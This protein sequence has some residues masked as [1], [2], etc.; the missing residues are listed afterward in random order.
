[1][2]RRKHHFSR[3]CV[4]GSVSVSRIP[5]WGWLPESQQDANRFGNYPCSKTTRGWRWIM[6]DNIIMANDHNFQCGIRESPPS[7]PE[8]AFVLGSFSSHQTPELAEDCQNKVGVNF[9][10]PLRRRQAGHMVPCKLVVWCPTGTCHKP[11]RGPV[12]DPHIYTAGFFPW[13]FSHVGACRASMGPKAE[14]TSI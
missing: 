13:R 4:S 11:S 14:K 7:P 6:R 3:A 10:G 12:G 8:F 1:M 9:G 5:C 2:G